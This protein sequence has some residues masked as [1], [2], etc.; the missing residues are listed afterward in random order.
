VAVRGAPAELLAEWA[1]DAEEGSRKAQAEDAAG[2]RAAWREWVVGAVKSRPEL[3]F[4]WAKGEASLPLVATEEGGR[5]SLDPSKVVE[6]EAG[7]WKQLWLP[8]ARSGGSPGARRARHWR[9]WTGWSSGAS[10]AD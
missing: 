6:R 1:T 9:R 10:P 5:W 2:R 4:R 3:L 8:G 7:K